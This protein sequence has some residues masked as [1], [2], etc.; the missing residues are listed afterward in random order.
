MAEPVDFVIK[1]VP[2]DLSRH[3]VLVLIGCLFKRIN[4]SATVDPQ[5]PGRG[6][7]A[8]RDILKCSLA[9]ARNGLKFGLG[10]RR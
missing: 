9:L 1:Q 8:H 3:G 10:R 7:I 2:Y 6:G 4:L 5:Y